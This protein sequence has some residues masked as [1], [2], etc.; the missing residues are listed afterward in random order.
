MQQIMFSRDDLANFW[1]QRITSSDVLFNGFMYGAAIR[2]FHTST[3]K[4]KRPAIEYHAR[5]VTLINESL[6]DPVQAC[7]DDNIFTVSNLAHHELIDQYQP[8]PV[9]IK[10][11][12]QG[13]LESLQFLDLYGGK[14]E[15]NMLHRHGMLT[16]IKRRGGMQALSLVP[17]AFPWCV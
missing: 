11:P 13:P 7:S 6:S 8:P 14:I 9:A 15:P 2:E 3:I 17:A 16:M 1:M 4:T 12:N 10:R 5:T